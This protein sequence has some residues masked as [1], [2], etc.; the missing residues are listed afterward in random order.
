MD[1]KGSHGAL[2]GFLLLISTVQPGLAARGGGNDAVESRILPPQQAAER[3]AAKAD[4]LIRLGEVEEAVV[5]LEDAL[6]SH[7]YSEVL[8]T[9]LARAYQADG[10]PD[11]A[12]SLLERAIGRPHL[13]SPWLW[14][15]LARAYLEAGRPKEAVDR[16]VWMCERWP[17]QTRWVLE[18]LER[19]SRRVPRETL[20]GFLEE[21]CRSGDESTRAQRLR[22]L[23][24]SLVAMKPGHEAISV[25]IEAEKAGHYKGRLIVDAFE[26]LS[27]EG[28]T[29]LALAAYDSLLSLK[30]KRWLPA[31][32]LALERA[33]LLEKSG[34]L[35]EALSAYQEIESRY[36]TK[37]IAFRAALKR[38][39]LLLHEL[40]RVEQAKQ[41][42]RGIIERLNR[43]PKL[44][45]RMAERKE[46]AL[47]ALADCAFYE[48]A[49]KEAAMSFAELEETARGQDVRE[50]AAFK[51]AE[52]LFLAGR[53]EEAEAA[54]YH[55]LDTY[56]SSQWANDALERIL[57]LG[58]N[59]G[60]Q[61]G[62]SAYAD[63]LYA[64]LAGKEEDALR[65]C[66]E[67]AE[68][69]EPTQMRG[70]I[71][72]E[73]C[74][75]LL[76]AGRLAEADSLVRVMADQDSSSRW[77]PAAMLKLAQ[78]LA[79]FPD[80]LAAARGLL[81]DLIVRYPERLEARRARD[82]LSALQ[83]E[84]REES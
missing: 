54:Y 47:L 82:M 21:R 62:L 46:E 69:L 64:R 2:I 26:T 63:L 29:A 48:G 57:L 15:L 52:M 53:F 23:G 12:V 40:G 49:F 65:I 8:V 37:E 33:G 24:L 74:L 51:R 78:S 73:E 13:D 80:S 71:R 27:R 38:A 7:P 16:Y 67:A 39:H 18:Q 35:E 4:R 20:L 30:G 6:K 58:E 11:S 31:D 9:T 14:N 10:E 79:V 72:M 66:S 77:T 84:P 45:R 34:R 68:R 59:A 22:L 43:D 81:E 36:G 55:V 56:T 75:L 50:E 83:E 61:P 70:R 19:M 44:A 5:L 28:H 25:L 41:I 3:L 32:R 60:D 1:R 42:Y 76:E 17:Q